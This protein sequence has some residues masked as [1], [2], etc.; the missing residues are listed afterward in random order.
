M[1]VLSTYR[2]EEAATSSVSSVNTPSLITIP[3][4]GA[5]AKQDANASFFLLHFLAHVDRRT[6]ITSQYLNDDLK[7]QQE[8]SQ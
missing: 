7:E 5:A 4:A 8:D 6:K 2:H 1:I 3:E